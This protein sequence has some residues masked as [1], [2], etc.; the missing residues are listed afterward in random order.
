MAISA[1]SNFKMRRLLEF[2]GWKAK[3]YSV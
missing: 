1:T 2:C 3:A